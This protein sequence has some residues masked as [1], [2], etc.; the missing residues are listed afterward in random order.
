MSHIRWAL[1]L[2]LSFGL[3]ACGWEKS[4]TPAQ[5][6][7]SAPS[8]ASSEGAASG[9]Q[10]SAGKVEKATAAVAEAQS[11]I[12]KI[13]GYLEDDKLDLA[14]TAFAQL[15]ALKGQLPASYQ[16]QVDN[17]G[18]IIDAK[19]LGNS[20]SDLFKSLGGG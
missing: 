8:G 3:F 7:G 1:P 19:E 14:K 17:L 15:T 4:S 13:T 16:A 12:E 11:L 10:G 5:N 18:T 2:A 6:G 9:S 20:A